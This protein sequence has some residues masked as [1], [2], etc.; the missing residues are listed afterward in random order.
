MTE[1]ISQT[2]ACVPIDFDTQ[3]LEIA[4]WAKE[5]HSDEADF[6]PFTHSWS[7]YETAMTYADYYESLGNVID[8]RVLAFACLGHDILVHVPLDKEIIPG[9]KFES[10]EH[11]SAWIF[12]NYL[13]SKGYS[14]ATVAKP[15]HDLI[16]T[17]KNGEEL[18]TIESVILC[19]S[20]IHNTIEDLEVFEDRALAF[21]REECKFKKLTCTFTE[22]LPGAMEYLAGFLSPRLP[23]EFVDTAKKHINQLLSKYGFGNMFNS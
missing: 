7:V 3:I 5:H 23:Q 21:Y 22:W 16:I 4:Q 2:E 14:E 6:H 10:I 15:V 13:I 17:S 11:R 8:R 18:D 12:S 9:Q 19:M 1:V 20:D